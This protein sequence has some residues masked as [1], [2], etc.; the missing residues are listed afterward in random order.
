MIV[1]ILDI[2][3]EKAQRSQS[4]K[5]RMRFLLCVSLPPE[6]GQVVPSLLSECKLKL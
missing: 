6:E 4:L 5:N 3:F 1:A 2:P